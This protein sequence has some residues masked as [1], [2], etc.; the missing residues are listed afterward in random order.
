MA[1]EFARTGPPDGFPEFTDIPGGRYTSEEFFELERRH[2][3]S[4]VWVLAGRAEDVARAGDYMT[5]DDLGVPIVI[6]RGVD[7]QIRAFYNT[8]QHRGAPVV[9]EARGTAR[10]LR[11]QYHSWTYEITTGSLTHVPDERDFVGLCRDE[12][13]LVELSCESWG[14][15]VFV[16]QAP[17]ARPLRRVLRR[18]ARRDGAVPGRARSA[19][20]R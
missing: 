8:C 13:A 16:N 10:A 19:P 11:C 3:W 2:L 15:W 20:S 6:V 4:N 5:F 18:G 1:W 9:R 14:G 17:E 12:R 7:D